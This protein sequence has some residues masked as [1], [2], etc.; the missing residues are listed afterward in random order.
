MKRTNLTKYKT[1]CVYIDIV[2]V[3]FRPKMNNIKVHVGDN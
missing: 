2:N 1:N 3:V